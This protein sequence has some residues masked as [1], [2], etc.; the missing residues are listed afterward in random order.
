MAARIPTPLPGLLL[1]GMLVGGCAHQPASQPVER[2][3]ASSAPERSPVAG[4]RRYVLDEALNMLGVPYRHGGSTPT[5]FD[6]S[7]LV[8]YSHL[9]AGIELPRTAQ[10]QR[11]HSRVVTGQGLQPGD[12]VFF[13]LAG[14]GVD[15]VGIYVG[16][17]QF[18]HA[19]SSGKQV[20]MASLD[21]PYWQRRLAGAGHYY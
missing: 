4:P 19:P 15:H 13:R 9:R 12:L 14:R 11:S 8:Y 7:G 2:P 20:S 3:P 18:V 6:C 16:N 10:Q 5:G 21:N 1:L 17:G